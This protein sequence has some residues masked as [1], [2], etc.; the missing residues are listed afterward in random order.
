MNHEVFITCALTGAGDTT[1]KS[2]KVPVT[3]EQIAE[4]GIAAAKAGAAVIHIHVRDPESG[5]PAR[6]PELYRQVVD[7]V[8]NSGVNVVINLTAGMGGDLVLGSPEKPLP[9]VEAQTDMA[10]AEERLRHVELIRPEI[11]SLD[12]G[13]RKSVV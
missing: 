3:P 12:C 4:S 7:R 1:G 11:C 10:S 5:A 2:D 6:D 9:L 13:D 8:R